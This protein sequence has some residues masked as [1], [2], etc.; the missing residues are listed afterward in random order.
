[1]KFILGT[2]EEMTQ[3]YTD[4]GEAFAATIVRATPNVVTQVRTKEKDGYTAVQLGAQEQ[5]ASRL[6]KSEVGHLKG[7]SPVS[8]LQEFRVDDAGALKEG[9]AVAVSAFT[10]GDAVEVTGISKGKGFQGVVK[11]HHFKGGRRSHGQKHSENEPGSIGGGLRTRVPKGMRMAGRMG[12]DKIT[13]K[14][15]RVLKVL[16]EQN[17]L[18]ISGALP[19]HRGT[20]LAIRAVK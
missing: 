13:V 14:N 20:L 10:E 15:L 17:L 7:K 19:G 9:D 8:H 6:S 2:K 18:V 3:M 12:G 16:P 11:R 1:M 4:K 5:K